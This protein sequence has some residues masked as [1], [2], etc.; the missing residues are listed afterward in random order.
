MAVQF[1]SMAVSYFFHFFLISRME[2]SEVAKAPN[3]EHALKF[4]IHWVTRLVRPKCD[5]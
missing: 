4:H 1:G 5:R 2:T 3:L